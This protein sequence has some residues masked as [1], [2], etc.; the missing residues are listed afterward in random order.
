MSS[1]LVF[2]SNGNIVI[3]SAG[4]Y[5]VTQF[6]PKSL[7]VEL[8]NK[9]FDLIKIL[10]PYIKSLS[11]KYDRIGGCGDSTIALAL[12]ELADINP[13][14]DIQIR[15]PNI[16]PLYPSDL[17]Y[18]GYIDG[19]KLSQSGNKS[20]VTLNISGYCGQLSRVRV[21]HT[22]SNM[23]V[24][25]I[26]KDILD[27][28]VLP[29]T[30]IIYDEEDIEVSDFVI[31]TL[32]F[33]TMADDA[34]KT[35]AN[36]SGSVE[37]GVDRERKFF[38][39]KMDEEIKHYVR[40]KVDVEKYAP[41]NDYD[42][43]INKYVIKG[44]K[45]DGETFEETVNNT[46]SQAA[47]GIRTKTVSNSA[48]VTSGVTQRYGTALLAENARIQRRVTLKIVNSVKFFEDNIPLGRISVLIDAVELAKKYGDNDAIYGLCRYGGHPSFQI[49]S[50]K[51]A[52]GNRSLDI[53]I[54]AGTA[55]PDVAYQ[56]KQLE[57]ELDQMRNG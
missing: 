6:V 12:S 26:V 49:N 39:K 44:G 30:K 17:V 34:I 25:L 16:N 54:D 55:K 27:N 19:E 32:E 52:L 2:D 20:S 4:D 53:D 46:E 28:Y 11:W 13:D 31:D 24:S 1:P 43:I 18:R 45:V 14:Y 37:Y 21:N 48:I 40:Y 23:E 7:S 15:L 42:D 47:Y 22:Y 29:E 51:Y 35:L 56:I 3:S 5:V 57:Y 33:D 10:N 50:V 41:T 9:N 36:L 8:R 38:F